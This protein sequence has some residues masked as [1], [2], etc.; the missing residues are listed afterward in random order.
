[1]HLPNHG[2]P[3]SRPADASRRKKGGLDCWGSESDRG[4]SFRWMAATM[5]PEDLG[6][7]VGQ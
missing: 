4:V 1:M 2:L 7:W 3:A 6:Y 5:V